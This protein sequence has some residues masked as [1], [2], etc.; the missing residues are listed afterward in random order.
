MVNEW[1]LF[2]INIPEEFGDRG[3]RL[4]SSAE[5]ASAGGARFRFSASGQKPPHSARWERT[6]SAV[7]S[8]P[9]EPWNTAGLTNHL[10]PGVAAGGV[11]SGFGLLPV[12]R[13][14]A[15]RTL[16]FAVTQDVMSQPQLDREN[17]AGRR[18]WGRSINDRTQKTTVNP[19][20]RHASR[21]VMRATINR[22]KLRGLPRCQI[23]N[24]TELHVKL[25]GRSNAFQRGI[26]GLA[27]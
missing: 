27:P 18:G 24:L 5:A 13:A 20:T 2:E 8:S 23:Q 11:Q 1:L 9:V 19:L 22:C 21:S 14:V 6:S 15:R 10:S 7:G 4:Q 16:A 17:T 25:Q 3:G 26:S 12:G